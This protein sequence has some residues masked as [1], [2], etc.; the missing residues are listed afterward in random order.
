MPLNIT[1]SFSFIADG[2]SGRLSPRN[3][4]VARELRAAGLGTLLFD[5]LSEEEAAAI[6]DHRFRPLDQLYWRSS[7]LDYTTV[8]DLIASLETKSDDPLLRPAPLAIDLAVLKL[9]AEDPAIAATRGFPAVAGNVSS[10]P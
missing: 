5:L 1:R 2:S 6:E 9:L 7:D 3:A 4:A 8:T 10:M